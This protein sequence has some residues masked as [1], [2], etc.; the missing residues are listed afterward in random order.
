MRHLRG[1]S[2]HIHVNLP[3]RTPLLRYV[4]ANHGIFL[5][6][7]AHLAL[8]LCDSRTAK[9][10]EGCYTGIG[11]GRRTLLLLICISRGAHRKYL[12]IFLMDTH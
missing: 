12:A 6:F 9:S 1:W 3:N 5:R 2:D 11:D 8:G 10:K 7:P 4:P